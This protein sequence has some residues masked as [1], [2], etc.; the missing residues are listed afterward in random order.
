MHGTITDRLPYRSLLQRARE[1]VP[2]A[3]Q[4][5]HDF[6]SLPI[7]RVGLTIV[8]MVTTTYGLMLLYD[9]LGG[10]N[11][12][13]G[14]IGFLRFVIPISV[15]G[16]LHAAIF[17]SLTQWVATRRAKYFF[18]VAFPLQV[19]AILASFGT[20]WVHMNGGGATTQAF[21]VAQTSAERGV[22]VF[23]ASYEAVATLMAALA[24]HSKARALVEEKGG[25]TSCGTVAGD[26]RGPRYDLRMNDR[27]TFTSL[28]AE[29]AA[30][31][32]DVDELVN[33]AAALTAGSPDEAMERVTSLRSLVSEAKA[34]FESDPLLDQVRRTAEARILAGKGPIAVPAAKRGKKGENNFTCFDAEL[35]RRLEAVLG[36][37]KNIKP[38][39]EVEVLDYRDP[40]TGFPFALWRLAKMI[41]AP[42]FSLPTRESL[43]A[44]RQRALAQKSAVPQDRNWS[45]I[46]PFAVAT[47]IEGLLALLF[48][49]GRG[50][51]PLHPGIDHLE[52]LLKRSNAR[53]F[54]RIWRALG[55][56]Q[57][58]DAIRRALD[59][60][61]K[62]EGANAWIFVPLYGDDKDARVLH[63]VMEIMVG[64]GLA[65]RMYTGRGLVSRW[66]MRG[67]DPAR[68]ASIQNEAVR[69]YRVSATEYMAFILDALNRERNEKSFTGET[70]EENDH[71]I[72]RETPPGTDGDQGAAAKEG[73]PFARAA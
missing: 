48:L 9:T 60:H 13:K 41:G 38:L 47:A 69:I 32:K 28:N 7:W 35:E 22:R 5:L 71:G 37:I 16:A 10:D 26:G 3:V 52:G 19:V 56:S 57:D 18:V 72:Q 43:R 12:G 67:W 44:D 66:H 51:L 68:R 31:K 62:F 59:N 55:G 33:R 15:G 23:A 14:S 70:F 8:S 50:T 17:W 63:N 36:A 4:V 46:T 11:H 45:D 6:L 53:V 1:L 29:V 34:R 42:D 73:E 21:V 65:R 30:K 27:A 2:A 20:H 54:D 24:E 58:L 40:R 61:S 25:G 49:L 64:V 39:P